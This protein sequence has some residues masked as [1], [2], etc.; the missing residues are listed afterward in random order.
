MELY[1]RSS[2]V[3]IVL[4]ATVSTDH[5][6]KGSLRRDATTG[7]DGRSR[8][9]ELVRLHDLLG[10][11]MDRPSVVTRSPLRGSMSAP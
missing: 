8:S 2:S 4:P 3:G 10:R 6:G 9:E 5:K 1:N 11:L 7:I